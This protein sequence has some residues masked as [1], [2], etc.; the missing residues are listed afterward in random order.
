ML[1]G[2]LLYDGELFYCVVDARFGENRFYVKPATVKAAMLAEGIVGTT[3]A[4]QEDKFKDDF[5]RCRYRLDISTSVKVNT[6]MLNKMLVAEVAVALSAGIVKVKQTHSA[7]AGGTYQEV[8][9]AHTTF[10]GVE[11]HLMFDKGLLSSGWVKTEKLQLKLRADEVAYPSDDV[12]DCPDALT[13]LAKECKDTPKFGS[14]AGKFG[15]YTQL[16]SLVKDYATRDAAFTEL[17]PKKQGALVIQLTSKQGESLPGA[18]AIKCRVADAEQE[19]AGIY[20]TIEQVKEAHPDKNT[21]WI[22]DCH[23]KIV[24]DDMLD[25]VMKEL[26][27]APYISFDTE[28]TGL[29]INFYSREG[30]AD[31]LVGVCLSPEEGKGYYFPLQ[32]KKFN[33]LCNGDHNLFMQ[34]YM[35]TLLEKQKVICHN[36]SYDWKV[37]YIYDINVNCVFDTMLAFG[38]TKRYEYVNYPTGLKDLCTELFGIDMFEISDFIMTDWAKSNITFA[39][40]PYDLVEHYGPAD[41]DITLRLFNWC[42]RER[43]LE[44][45]EAERVFKLEVDFAK[46]VSY[47]EFWGYHI[48]IAKLPEL[49][50]EIVAGMERE[51]KNMFDIAGREF[52]PNS[53]GQ[54]AQIMYDELGIPVI[55]EK[56]S[57]SKDIL[58]ELGDYQNL[59]G[60]PMYPFVKHLLSYRKFEGT[61]KNF[62]KKKDQ[63]ISPEGFVFPKVYQLGTNTGRLSIHEPNYQ[64]YN[65]VVKKNVT[66]RPGYYIY[67]CDFA[68]VEYRVLASMAGESALIKA[69]DDPDL[70]YHQH[71]AAR[72]FSLP[73]AAVTKQ[74]RQQSK[75]INFGLPYGMGDESLG[76]RVFGAKTPENTAKAADLRK[77]FFD[78]QDN[79]LNFFE[80]VRANGVK[81]GY[82][83]TWLG[84]RR[85]YHKALFSEAA[86]RRQ[87]G[88]HVIQGCLSKDAQ[89]QTKEFGII[90]I[91]DI[92][93]QTVHVWDGSDWTQGLVAYSG[94][95]RKCIVH[96]TDGRTF[97]CSPDH[98]FAVV[99]HKGNRRFVPCSELIGTHT[100]KGRRAA[101][102]IAITSEYMPS[103]AKYLSDTTF[104]N[105]PHVHN[106]N[107]YKLDDIKSSFGMG[108]VLGRL[109]SDGNVMT[110]GVH[111][112]VMHIVGEHEFS[113]LPELERYMKK[114]G[115]NTSI[116]DVRKDKNERLGF[117]A[118][119]CKPL[120]Q[121]ILSLD[122][123]HKIHDAI[124]A[125]TEMLRG[126]LRG[127]FD[128]DGGVSGQCIM[129]TQGVQDDFEPLCRDI[130]KALLFFG[131][132]ARYRY[133]EG[134]RHAVQITK[135]DVP[136]FL[137]VIGFMNPD[138]QAK[139][140]QIKATFDQH[141]FGK[142]LLVDHVEMTD[143]Y[144]DMYDVCN[145]E[146]GYYVADGIVTHNSAADIWKTSVVRF[147]N[148][149]VKEGWLGKVLFCGFIHDELMGEVS[150]EIKPYTFIKAW[151]EEYEMAIEDFCKLYAGFGWGRSWYEAKKA[152]YPPYFIDSLCNKAGTAEDEAW[153]GDYVKLI[154]KTKAEM[155][156]YETNRVTTWLQESPR[157]T[158]LAPHIG[159]YLYAKVTDW[160]PSLEE[161]H[162]DLVGK[163]VKA[164]SLDEVW[165]LFAEHEGIEYEDGW[166][167]P[168][169]AVKTEVNKVEMTE[170]EDE[171]ATAEA[172]L[173]ETR[174]SYAKHI[175]EQVKQFN[176]CV[177]TYLEP[178]E[179]VVYLKFI[180]QEHAIA[181]GQASGVPADK[182]DIKVRFIQYFPDGTYQLL[183]SAFGFTNDNFGTAQLVCQKAYL[184]NKG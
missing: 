8:W 21:A 77:R 67:D 145:T 63:F 62:L 46:V 155:Y 74:L 26:W 7:N 150:V 31:E 43:L 49:E 23:Y 68:Q 111:S 56:R 42:K 129:L 148:R 66:G 60:T 143:E 128:G 78:G 104:I 171:L 177:D 27:A 35:K 132:R 84:R 113:I 98:K 20:E 170:A 50:E 16:Y 90:H 137:E 9:G 164:L 141:T 122:I 133:Y 176:F 61:Y 184:T 97:V 136:R 87:A 4:E 53:S 156:D 28:T 120:A 81:K 65:D 76:K 6:T 64:S 168:S 161:K 151:R 75:G 95:K 99:S 32:H 123:R 36:L 173:A 30:T 40:L 112:R 110:D 18:A 131:I 157:G 130:Q 165:H 127:M 39:D 149:V 106:A 93:G 114:L 59:D 13:A 160:W 92:A 163:K 181:I 102:R 125:D 45:Y 162:P 153:D 107:V 24:T 134:D 54:L 85:Y 38:V 159:N 2:T 158:L 154:E 124:F 138:K 29:N 57:T 14:L 52:N 73:Y 147:F 167:L 83:S 17:L 182:A 169:D 118:T 41:A 121:E 103:D 51:K 89:I 146:R 47:S 15:M 82:T 33:N 179:M 166:I 70:D 142:C 86:I 3:F 126:F 69:F 172:N 175:V 140:S 152:D 1:I 180:S 116:Q 105:Q 117:V 48:D 10:D 11:A 37:A 79:I 55:G 91:G 19:A 80:T 71:Q 144:I 12:F 109:A 100:E 183:D 88:N 34:K 101:H 178:D 94:K 5:A 72:M 96:F 44:K 139:A 135:A 174:K 25:D 119:Y 108:V 22:E 115:A 58:K